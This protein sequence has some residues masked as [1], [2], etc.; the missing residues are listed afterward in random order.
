MTTRDLSRLLSETSLFTHQQWALL[1]AMPHLGFTLLY[2]IGSL[3][4]SNLLGKAGHSARFRKIENL[5]IIPLT[6]VLL[7]GWYN[8]F[9]IWHEQ[10]VLGPILAILIGFT[11]L[12]FYIGGIL[13]I[14]QDET[15]ELGT[16]VIR[17]NTIAYK[18]V[19]DY[20]GLD[21]DERSLCGTSWLATIK[22]VGWTIIIPIGLVCMSGIY[23]ARFLF[24]VLLIL[25][26]AEPPSHNWESVLDINW[27]YST[28][29]LKWYGPIPISPLFWLLIVWGIIIL[30]STRDNPILA[31]LVWISLIGLGIIAAYTLIVNICIK[32]FT[33]EVAIVESENYRDN[34][35]RQIVF[36]QSNPIVKTYT[37]AI[38]PI[39]M[40]FKLSWKLICDVKKIVCPT[41]MVKRD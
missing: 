11:L 20:A 25:Y 21:Y 18:L 15:T 9:L 12:V 10:S 8:C 27:P 14:S 2:L 37:S 28:R 5:M 39:R 31:V 26:R 3:V 41:V 30:W 13:A 33:D 4:F 16:Y 32:I 34:K 23:I 24:W 7:Y 35:S 40:T 38:N 29:E 19:Y 6:I 17:R 1:V 36:K 22:A